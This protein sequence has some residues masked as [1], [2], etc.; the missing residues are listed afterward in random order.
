MCALPT[1]AQQRGARQLTQEHHRVSRFARG[2][3]GQQWQFATDLTQVSGVKDA[4]EKFKQCAHT[5]QVGATPSVCLCKALPKSWHQAQALT[6]LP[7]RPCFL[8][9][10]V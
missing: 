3:A 5:A 7:W 6:L 2:G 4:P 9:F 10:C 1:G 8:I